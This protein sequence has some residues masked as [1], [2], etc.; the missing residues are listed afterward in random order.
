MHPGHPQHWFFKVR[1]HGVYSHRIQDQEV[2]GSRPKGHWVFK[3]QGSKDHCIEGW[4]VRGHKVLKVKG[5]VH[6]RPKS[7]RV[8]V[9]PTRLDSAHG[10]TCLEC[11]LCWQ[12]SG[13]CYGLFTGYAENK[14]NQTLIGEIFVARKSQL[15]I[16]EDA[17]LL[18]AMWMAPEPHRPHGHEAGSVLWRRWCG[19][20]GVWG[21][22][23]SC[24]CG[25]KRWLHAMVRLWCYL[26]IHLWPWAPLM[27][28]ILFPT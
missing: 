10:G 16:C 1:A 9:V 13:L 20:W 11:A 21:P 5:N 7:L 17:V 28:W 3:G 4:Q 15:D 19:C 8:T 12:G 27:S 14:P 2:M 18:T 22:T 26:N 24:P 23:C 6:Q 25:Y